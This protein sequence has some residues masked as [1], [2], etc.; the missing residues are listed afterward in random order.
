MKG[1]TELALAA[2]L[3][4]LVY[5]KPTVLTEFANSVLGKTI[6]IILIVLIAKTRGLTA[7]V[8]AALI[9]MIL[10]HESL[11]GF[12]IR[13]GHVAKFNR[14]GPQCRP[15]KKDGSQ[16]NCKNNSQCGTCYTT[17]DTNTGE[18]K[19]VIDPD[20]QYLET[21]VAGDAN[22]D[23]G[24]FDVR[25]HEGMNNMNARAN[26][27]EAMKFQNGFTGNREQFQGFI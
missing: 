10:M 13:E 21:E 20:F 4:F 2:I 5:D 27:I 9:M 24:T 26:T 3:L 1:I 18:C 17:C 12:G 25:L 23:V 19:A 11:E 15:K 6:L 7:G 14:K 8:I 16:V 22:K